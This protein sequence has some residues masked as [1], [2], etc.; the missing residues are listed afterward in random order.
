MC[1]ILLLPSLTGKAKKIG[2]QIFLRG[3][4]KRGK[5]PQSAGKKAIFGI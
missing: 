4:E 1:I 2:L 3:H 5:R